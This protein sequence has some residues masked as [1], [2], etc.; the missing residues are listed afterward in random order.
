MLT[1]AEL[2]TVFTGSTPSTLRDEYYG[3]DIPFVTP[4]ELNQFTA[5]T[6]AKRTLSSR[7]AMDAG[8][9]PEGAVLVCCIGSLGKTGIAGRE[10]AANQQINSV[11]FDRSKIFPRYGFHAC[12]LLRGTL[13]AIAPATTVPIVRKSKFEQ[14][15]IPVPPLA[16][17]REIA[18]TLDRAEALRAKRRTTLSELDALTRS[19]FHALCGDPATNPRSWPTAR[20]AELIRDD[21]G[22]NY[23]VV[24]PGEDVEDGVPLIRVGDLQDGSINLSRLKKI[25]TSIEKKYKRSRLHGDEIL[26]SCVGSIG[27]VVLAEISM[28]GFN[29]ARAV[30]RIR[31]SGKVNRN[32]VAAYL[33]TDF[34]QKYFTRELRTA[35]QPTLN[36]KQI[37]ETEVRLPPENIQNELARQVAMVDKLKSAHR[38]FLAEL[39]ALFASLEHRAFRGENAQESE[40]AHS[41]AP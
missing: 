26:V 14:V 38:A 25:A 7:G 4:A 6:C 11:V 34:V 31:L 22:I 19:I 24:Q 3:G 30:A 18:D 39:D 2:G 29:I 33:Q 20:L 40:R 9:L 28:K 16:H 32:Y 15:K 41:R 1:L 37:A 12:R 8:I 23:G 36:I 21:D 35:S 5:I 27:T 10:V 13:E 17:Q